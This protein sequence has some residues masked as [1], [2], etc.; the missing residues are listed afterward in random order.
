M[1]TP[2]ETRIDILSSNLIRAQMDAS[3]ARR[4]RDQYGQKL[5]AANRRIAELEARSPWLSWRRWFAVAV[6]IIVLCVLVV[7]AAI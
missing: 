7:G 6:V 3:A 1:T 4:Q 5:A 2:N